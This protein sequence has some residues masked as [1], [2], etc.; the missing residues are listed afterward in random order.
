MKLTAPLYQSGLSTEVPYAKAIRSLMYVALRTRPDLAFTVQHL[1]QPTTTYRPEHWTMVKHTLRYLQG[2]H[3]DRITFK[4]DASLELEI[5]VSSDYANRQDTLSISGYMTT[6]GGGVIAWSSKKQHMIA[7]S[8]MEA[9]YMALT[10]GTK[11]LIW[12]CWFIQELGI[13]QTHPTSLQLDNLGVITLSHDPTYHAHTKH[14]NVAYHFIHEKVAS[15]E[16][17]L[18][19]VHTKENTVDIL[20]KGLDVQ[21]H[22]YLMGKLGMETE[23]DFSLRGSVSNTASLAKVLG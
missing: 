6:L 9:E 21:Q 3:D 15:H 17:T 2:S 20:T 18:T 19:Y 1:S 4:R 22:K 13:D 10:K 8:T 11:Q 7:L 12:L 16:A 5:F 14:I 23:G